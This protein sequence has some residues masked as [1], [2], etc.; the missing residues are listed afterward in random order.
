MAVTLG[1]FGGSFDPFHLG[2][3]RL[4][5]AA[6]K[7]YNFTSFYLIP[8]SSPA[9]KDRA[10]SLAIY[11]YT[12]AELATADLNQVKLSRIE[13]KQTEG[14]NYTFNTLSKLEKKWA[15][16]S[17]EAVKFKLVLGSD[18]LDYFESWYKPE[19]ILAQAD[20]LIALRGDDAKEAKAYRKKAKAL[21]KAY[22]G[23]IEFFPMQPL[24]ISS[25]S[26]RQQLQEGELKKKYYQEP[27]A[28]F[29]RQHRPYH[30]YEDFQALQPETHKLLRTYEQA[31]WHK[32]PPQRLVH[33]ANVCLYA[34]HLARL[35][36]L[37][38]DKAALAG[39]LHDSCKHIPLPEQHTYVK[40]SGFSYAVNAAIAH[41]PASAYW[42]KMALGLD[43][44]D[45]YQAVMYHT[46][47]RPGMTPLEKV[48]YL[49]DKIEFGR[50]FNHL[51]KIR[52]A[53]ETDLDEAMRLCLQEVKLAMQR[54][55]TSMHE[56]TVKLMLELGMF[57]S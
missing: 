44:Q 57:L 31:I 54:N 41:G 22:G 30:F 45:I 28:D 7:A 17:K 10:L 12:M 8:T 23:S 26:L 35:H 29:I 15:K 11:R 2:H 51:E 20:L 49:A 38:A 5:E 4:L 42:N 9:Y 36:D 25:T 19:G 55:F 34:V 43:D 48:I 53:A 47:G 32:L 52:Q 50:P 6:L 46:T 1:I 56:L 33:V 37:D 40:Q 3:R 16:K 21:Q 24:E 27:V 18:A 13:L 39:L 14:P